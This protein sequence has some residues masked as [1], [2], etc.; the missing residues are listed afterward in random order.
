MVTSTQEK[1]QNYRL[2]LPKQLLHR[3]GLLLK[4]KNLHN[5][6]IYGA[7]ETYFGFREFKG[8][9][10]PAINSVLNG[11]DTF[12]IMPTGGGKAFVTSCLP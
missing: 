5:Y 12:V 1:A 9:Q 3:K 7:L 11:R 8:T 10:E 2:Q 4:S 6:D